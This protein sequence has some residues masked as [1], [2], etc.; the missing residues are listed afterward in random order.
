MA[1]LSFIVTMVAV[2]S[3]CV[4]AE[5]KYSGRYDDIDLNEILS[6]EKLRIQYY[7]CFMD[8]APCKTADA[9]FFKGVIGEAMQ[10]QC[11]RCTE[12]QKVLLDHMADWYTTN[13]PDE[14]N[15]FV[16]KTIEDARKKNG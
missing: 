9:K 10:T 4:F 12:K 6:N 2:A 8:T 3:A 11:R 5:E 1:R 14:W 15:A 16:R 7:N 13:K